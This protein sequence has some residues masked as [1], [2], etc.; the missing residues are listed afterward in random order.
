MLLAD[1]VILCHLGEI[2]LLIEVFLKVGYYFLDHIVLSSSVPDNALRPCKGVEHH[3]HH[4]KHDLKGELVGI[5]YFLFHLLEDAVKLLVHRVIAVEM[6]HRGE[7]IAD[8]FRHHIVGAFDE[9]SC[10]LLRVIVCAVNNAAGNKNDIP[11]G[12]LVD[13]IVNKVITAARHHVV[14]LV[15]I[16]I[17]VRVHNVS[18]VGGDV[19]PESVIFGE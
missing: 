4:I 12:D 5:V 9:K 19:D 8:R 6:K 1:K 11:R 2:Y 10:M 3:A 14:D 7:R 13:L 18:Y 17:V 15:E 16:V